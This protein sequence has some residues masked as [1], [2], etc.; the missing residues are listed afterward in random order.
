[1]RRVLIAALSG[2]FLTL[3][4]PVAGPAQAAPTLPPFAVDPPGAND[5]SCRPSAA[6]PVPVVLVHGTFGDRQHLLE[7]LSATLA[8]RGW[9]VFSLDYGNRGTGDVAASAAELKRYVDRVLAA[10]GAARVSLVGHSQ[11]GMMPR[12]FIKNLGGAAVVDDLVGLAPS[13]HGTTLVPQGW[14]VPFC[15]AC[16]QQAAGSPFLT[17]LNAG[18]ETP[19]DVS[20]TQVTTRY[21]EVV[22]PHTSG[23]LAAGPQVTNLTVQDACPLDLSEHVLIP[24]SRASIAWTVDALSH[25]GPAD[26]A[27]DP[28]S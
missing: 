9:C 12:Y 2:L 18:D 24:T 28:C 3:V 14:S 11:G 5:W 21:D 8:G 16:D 17:A 23:H 15:V 4:A 27:L 25:A 20:Y 26:P 7:P 22:V 6:R 10:T 1:M 13:N 19:G